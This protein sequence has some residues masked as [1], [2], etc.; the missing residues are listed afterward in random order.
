MLPLEQFRIP[1]H[2]A[3][4]EDLVETARQGI[5]KPRQLELQLS[6]V[7]KVRRG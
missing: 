5:R 6:W 3:V 4:R 2:E 1:G 7:A